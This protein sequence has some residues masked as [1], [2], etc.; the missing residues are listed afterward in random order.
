LN[1]CGWLMLAAAPVGPLGIAM[2][3]GDLTLLGF[4]AVLI[5]VNF[6]ALRQAVTPA[7]MLGRMTTT[8]RWLVLVPAGPGALIGGWL[9]Q[10]FGLR[11]ALVFAGMGGLAL[12][13]A[14]LRSRR[15][16]GM[17]ALPVMAEAPSQEGLLF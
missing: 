13:V 6:L 16:R 1:A 11:A 10:H 4:G 8:M 7:P 5:F 14:A 12:T 17:R 3:A 9:G 15:V 2:F